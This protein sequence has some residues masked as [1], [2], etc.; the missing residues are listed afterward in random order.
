MEHLVIPLSDLEQAVHDLL[1]QVMQLQEEN[2][3]LKEE[4]RQLHWTLKEQD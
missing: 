2:R 3:A 1:K 4:I